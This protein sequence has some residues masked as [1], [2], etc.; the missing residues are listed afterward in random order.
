[1]K[2]VVL[3]NGAVA[4]VNDEDYILVSIYTWH[5]NKKGHTSY[6]VRYNPDH[7]RTDIYMHRV[8][9]CAGCGQEVDHKNGNGLDNRRNNIRICSKITNAQNRQNSWGSSKYRGI[10]WVKDRNVWSAQIQINGKYIHL[11]RFDREEDAAYAY[12]LAATTYF[13]EFAHLNEL[14]P[15]EYNATPKSR[16]HKYHRRKAV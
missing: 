2:K 9:L 14:P 7:K 8:I 12:N 5:E 4:L 13:G 1:M 6:A 16:P 11:G 3:S 10:S 15:G